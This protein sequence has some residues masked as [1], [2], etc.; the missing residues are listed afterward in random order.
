MIQQRAGSK[1]ISDEVDMNVLKREK[2]LELWLEGCRWADLVRWG[3]IDGV[4]KAGQNVTV[5]Y[6]KLSRPVSSTDE[7]VKFNP[8]DDRF[9][10][11][12]THAAKDRGDKIG[13]VQGKHE[14]FPFPNT[15][16]SK[17]ANLK[18]NPGWE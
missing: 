9:Y 5:L 11:V 2:R 16:T 7:N 1:T 10:T 13:F 12:T 8:A 3:D 4:K 6:D 18:Q 14:F 17:N 15:V